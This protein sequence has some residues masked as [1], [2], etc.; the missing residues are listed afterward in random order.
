LEK[1]DGIYWW[2]NGFWPGMLWQMY[3]VANILAGR[4]NPAGKFIRAWNGDRTGW[5]IIDCLMNI[6]ILYWASKEIEDP[7]SKWS[8][9]NM[10][11]PR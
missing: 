9:W 4:Y 8:V 7:A 3:H 11:T 2:A 5:I 10:P 1:P 6:P